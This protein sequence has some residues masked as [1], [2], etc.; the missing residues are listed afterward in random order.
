MKINI[1]RFRKYALRSLLCVGLTG[2]AD[3]AH[4]QQKPLLITTEPSNFSKLS[5]D[6]GKTIY[7]ATAD[8]VH[9]LM[10]R[11]QIPYQMQIMSWKRAFELARTQPNTCV[12]ETA[13]TPDR[14]NSF[15]W[16]GPISHGEWGIYGTP[17]K[18]GRI[19]RLADIKDS[20]IGG[21]LG[22]AIGEYLSQHNFHVINSYDDDITLKNL[23][24]GRLDYWASD[25]MQAPA[26]IANNHVKDKVAQ[27]FTFGSYEYYLACNPDV[28]D[29]SIELMRAKL[30][31][32]KTD[33]TEAR[34]SARY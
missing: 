17:D 10:R 1:A 29:E 25:T 3:P 30:K 20:T 12:F 34:I 32:I 8:K 19:N 24:V 4:C 7:G 31:E 33:G 13:R 27:L 11:T 14:E 5:I 28:S 16:I 6:D 2:L 15:K 23:L 9:E 18:V 26:M 21:Y 22:D